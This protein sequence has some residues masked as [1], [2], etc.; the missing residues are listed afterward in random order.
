[1]VMNLCEN[2]LGIYGYDINGGFA[3]YVKASKHLA[4]LGGVIEIPERVSYKEPSLCEPLSC[5]LNGLERSGVSVGK[6]VTIIGAGP[7]GLMHPMLS[8]EVG[9]TQIIVG[10]VS[11]PR[12]K[13]AEKMGANFVIDANAENPVAK[14]KKLTGGIGADMVITAVGSPFCNRASHPNG[15]KRWYG[16][17]FWWMSSRV[18]CHDRPKRD[19]LQ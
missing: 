9:A 2:M 12:I 10:D 18:N 4:D 5:C 15:P 7:I 14:V 11:E 8:K 3:E 6:S 1:M 13:M 19:S 17:H 16:K